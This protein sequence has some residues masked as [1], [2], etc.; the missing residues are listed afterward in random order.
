MHLCRIRLPGLRCSKLHFMLGF[1]YTQMMEEIFEKYAD[2]QTDST[3]MLA[4]LVAQIRPDKPH[5]TNAAVH[6]IQALCYVLNRNA[7]HVRLLRNAMLCLLGEHKPV[8]LYVDSGIQ[9]SSGFFTEMQR[10][11][12]H[13]I[14]PDAVDPAYLKHLFPRI[15]S[16][17][18]DEIWVLAVPDEV[19]LAL[20][21]ALHFADATPDQIAPCQQALLDAAQVLS[22]RLAASGLE[23]ELIRNHP[24]LEDLASPFI[25][26]N[27]ELIALLA[28]PIEE[29]A[30][31]DHIL[32]ILDQCKQGV[33]E[34]RRNS[35]Q[36][37]TSINLTVL[38]QG[39]SQKIAR[40][41]ILLGITHGLRSGESAH[42]AL[43]ALFKALVSAECHK[44]DLGQHWRENMETL[45]LRVTENASRTGEHYITE[46]RGEYFALMRSAMGAGLVV[47]IMAM[48]KIM[49]ANEHYAPL[50]EAIL[51]SLNYGLGFVLIHILHFTVATKQPAMTAAAI[52]A[53][54]D[55]GGEGDKDLNKLVTII[56]QTVRSQI[57]AIFG[58]V[59]IAIPVAMLIAWSS[60]SLTGRH[61]VGVEE[62]H[63]LLAGIDPFHSGALF[64]AGIAGVCLFL[65]GLIAGYHDNI[66]IYNKIPQRLMALVWMQKLLGQTRLNRVGKYIENNL[67]ALAGNFYFGCLLGGMGGIGVL[68]GVPIDIRHIAFSSAFFSF[69]LVGLDFDVTGQMLLIAVSGV[70]LIGMVNLLVSFSLAL[71]VAM[72]SR[73]LSFAQWRMLTKAVL[74]RLNQ[75]PVD[76]L[77]P[78]KK[79]KSL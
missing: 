33:A 22:Y 37:G 36:S 64:Y 12:G 20:L 9:P 63:Y 77:L 29:P 25:T 35:S 15:F 27:R 74:S 72:K 57:V 71:Y 26:Q 44:N 43:I 59:I 39:M 61:F 3:E 55:A 73:K 47:G 10:R 14:L 17:I 48:I 76:F 60:F 30:G 41:E 2:R 58:N 53:S 42:H 66:A 79:V 51:F 21:Q 34:I 50:T 67:G 19:W 5:Q 8:S 13:K 16:K 1:A 70:V 65:A 52:A 78:P 54:I 49:T 32:A 24:E 23:P 62:A 7:G 46:S 28:S 56:I 40:L 38:L 11:I 45:A 6:A 4:E 18:S 31:I 68:L 69:S 75:N